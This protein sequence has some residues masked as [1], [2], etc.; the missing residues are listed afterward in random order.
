MLGCSFDLGPE[1]AQ[2]PR[3]LDLEANE[4]LGNRNEAVD[5]LA[6]CHGS[7]STVVSPP[8]CYRESDAL[9]VQPMLGP[10]SATIEPM[11]CL[12]DA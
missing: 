3:H 10:V 5:V 4:L 8:V 11:A 2:D 1:Y 6:E 9:A 12:L 7:E